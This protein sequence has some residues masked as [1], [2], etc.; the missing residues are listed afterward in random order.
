MAL[1]AG[2]ISASLLQAEAEPEQDP[3][4]ANPFGSSRTRE[5]PLRSERGICDQS[6]IVSIAAIRL[7]SVVLMM[8]I[9]R[10]ARGCSS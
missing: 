5:L 8:N 10:L 7:S 1:L 6:L 2:D 3:H 4:L 9:P